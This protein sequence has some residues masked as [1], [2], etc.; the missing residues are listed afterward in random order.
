MS[1]A[2]NCDESYHDISEMFGPMDPH[3]YSPCIGCSTS[4]YGDSISDGSSDVS[5]LLVDLISKSSLLND[6][7]TEGSPSEDLIK[8]KENTL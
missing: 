8:Q 1:A 5:D 3:T 6:S 7:K 4:I 2:E